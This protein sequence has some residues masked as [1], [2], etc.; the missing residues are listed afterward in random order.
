MAISLTINNKTFN[1]PVA[2]EDPGWGEDTTGWIR[3]VNKVVN[4]LFGPGDILET[5]FNVANNVSSSADIVG[6]A[7]NPS[8]IRAAHIEYSIYRI[9]D[10]E[11]SGN[12]ETG[13]IKLIYDDNASSGNKWSFSQ[14]YTGDA[15]VTFDI[16]DTG[17]LT[18]TSTDIGATGYTGTMKFKATALSQ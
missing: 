1:I 17:Q 6:L 14:E 2:G 4:S 8:T 9:S 18:Y 5:T 15:G 16:T 3:E 12:A 10:S 7:F 13:E 11:T